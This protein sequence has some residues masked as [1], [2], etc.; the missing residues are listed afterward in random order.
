MDRQEVKFLLNYPE[1]N[2]AHLNSLQHEF[3]YSLKE[4]YKS[5]GVLTKRQAECLS[6][7]KKSIP[8][9]VPE[10]AVSEYESNNCAAQYSSLDF[11]TTFNV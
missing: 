11:L 10:G 6:E 7:I 2:P 5:T 3:V 4:H 1:K 8:T 9:L